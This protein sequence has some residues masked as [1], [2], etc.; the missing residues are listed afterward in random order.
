M[1]DLREFLSVNNSVLH[2]ENPT[3]Q[4]ATSLEKH[5]IVR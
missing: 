3:L 1:G 2:A 4:H 5:I